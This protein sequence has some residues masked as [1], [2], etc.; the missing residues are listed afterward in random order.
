MNRNGTGAKAMGIASP[1]HAVL[2]AT[3]VTLGI[4]GLIQGKLTPTWTGV[5]KGF[6]AWAS[7]S[8]SPAPASSPSS[9]QTRKSCAIR[10]PLDKGDQSFIIIGKTM[11]SGGFRVQ[12]TPHRR[13]VA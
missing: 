6:P 1:G 9:S 10:S 8:A 7:A 4:L 2:A 3:L 12:G 5:P 13:F 11:P